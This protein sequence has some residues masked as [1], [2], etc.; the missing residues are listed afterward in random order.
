MLSIVLITRKNECNMTIKVSFD[1][2]RGNA[3]RNKIALSWRKNTA[4]MF[5][6][7]VANIGKCFASAANFSGGVGYTGTYRACE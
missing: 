6:L 5:G 1:C 3:M 7:A 4:S 2:I